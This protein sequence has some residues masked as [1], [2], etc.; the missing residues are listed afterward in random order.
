MNLDEWYA[1]HKGYYVDKYGKNY[2]WKPSSYD[3]YEPYQ[4]EC[5]SAVVSMLHDVYGEPSG[6]TYGRAIS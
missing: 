4:G 6:K 1:K 3:N 5:V 2:S